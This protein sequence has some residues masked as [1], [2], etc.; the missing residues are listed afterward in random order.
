VL[1]HFL[2]GGWGEM[3]SCCSSRFPRTANYG[4]ARDL[5]VECGQISAG[6]KLKNLFEL[7]NKKQQDIERLK[8]EIESLRIVVP[9]LEQGEPAHFVP[10]QRRSKEQGV[11]P[12]RAI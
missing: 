5:S 11:Q 2:E 8:R 6:A 12:V 1:A 9:M 7:L 4:F 10:L 3:I